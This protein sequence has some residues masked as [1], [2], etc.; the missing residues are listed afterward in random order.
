MHLLMVCGKSA[1]PPNHAPVL[2]NYLVSMRVHFFYDLVGHFWRIG[3]FSFWWNK[4]KSQISPLFYKL[5]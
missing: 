2:T 1:N 5:F 4:P 3:G